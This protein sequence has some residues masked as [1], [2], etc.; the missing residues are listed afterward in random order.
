MV[1]GKLGAEQQMA[2]AEQPSA[3]PSALEDFGLSLAPSDDNKG[4]VVTEVDPSGPAAERGISQGDVFHEQ[5]AVHVAKP[6]VRFRIGEIQQ[7]RRL[8]V[9]V[10]SG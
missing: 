6:G 10:Q 9:R 3:K 8:Q 4:V 7:P 1:L 2:A 5:V